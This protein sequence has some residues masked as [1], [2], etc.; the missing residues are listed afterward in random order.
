MSRGRGRARGDSVASFR[1]FAPGHTRGASRATM[2]PNVLRK[3]RS[4]EELETTTRE[5]VKQSAENRER[6]LRQSRLKDDVAE[7]ARR[8]REREIEL[9]SDIT[10]DG[11][12]F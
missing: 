4:K 10:G 3:E 11:G 8:M 6:L 5:F 1:S 12:F 7:A 2:N 9:N